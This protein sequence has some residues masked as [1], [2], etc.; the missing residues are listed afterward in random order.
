MVL[1]KIHNENDIKK[2]LYYKKLVHKSQ[3]FM[4]D[5]INIIY[6]FEY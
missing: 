2:I 5:I 4:C 3:F 1:E 6:L